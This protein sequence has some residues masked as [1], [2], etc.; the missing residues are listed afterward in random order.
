[1]VRVPQA[2]VIGAGIVG[3]SSAIQLRRRGLEVIVLE[4]RT[5]GS[6]AS[7]GNAG[8]IVPALS[9]PVAAPGAIGYGVRHLMQ[10]SGGFSIRPVPSAAM[11]HWAA[12]FALST[13]RSVFETGL[14]AT[15]RFAAGAARSFAD[16]TASG[17]ETPVRT[18]GMLIVYDDH[19]R[20]ARDLGGYRSLAG[21]GIAVDDDVLNVAE[22]ARLE[23]ALGR[24]T[25]AGIR[26]PNEQYVDPFQLACDLARLASREGVVIREAANVVRL[27]NPQAP[28]VHIHGGDT[29]E[30]SF[31]IVAAGIASVPLA[32]DL[33]YQ[34]PMQ[35]GKG[36]SVTVRPSSDLYSPVYIPS[37]KAALTPLKEGLRIAGVME[38]GA[39]STN[40]AVARLNRMRSLSEQF[41]AENFVRRSEETDQWAGLRPVTADSLPVIGPVP[42]A[43][44]AFI[45]TGH[46]M[47]GVTLGPL[48]GEVIAAQVAGEVQPLAQA[49]RPDRFSRKGAQ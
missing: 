32:K 5:V 34:L 25:R 8:W 47:L 48:T 21:F 40:I 42:G 3:L 39:K 30:H 14:S 38:L 35:A 17:L 24:S 22:L 6:G 36:Y 45:A 19:A 11:L 44:K 18:S 23:P 46:A 16:L 10:R 43:Q 2:V 41:F 20:A 33:G 9:A 26:F 28:R 1:M 4:A 31:V 27:S 13:R 12:R 7:K 37:A 29:I 15:A 49:F